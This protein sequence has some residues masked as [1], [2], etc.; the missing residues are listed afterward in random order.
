MAENCRMISRPSWFIMYHA[1]SGMN[2]WY[3]AS[4]ALLNI[5]AIGDIITIPSSSSS[6]TIWRPFQHL[7]PP[8]TPT[9]TSAY[10]TRCHVETGE[11]GQKMCGTWHISWLLWCPFHLRQHG[12]NHLEIL[13]WKT[14]GTKPN[15]KKKIG[16]SNSG[17]LGSAPQDASHHQDNSNSRKG[18]QTKTFTL[19]LSPDER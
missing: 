14:Q 16:G 6:S 19:P 5:V 18:S 8:K 10:H 2:R 7:V 13:G 1:F 3:R 4:F 17:Y 15:P 9:T 12:T 11:G